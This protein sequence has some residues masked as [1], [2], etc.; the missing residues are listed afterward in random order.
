MAKKISNMKIYENQI[1]S[2]SWMDFGSFSE[3]PSGFC[4]ECVLCVYLW[5]HLLCAFASSIPFQ[6]NKT[7]CS[8]NIIFV[9]AWENLKP[10]P[11]AS[12]SVEQLPLGCHSLQLIAY[13]LFFY[14]IFKYIFFFSIFFF[15]PRDYRFN[16][17][18]V[19]ASSMLTYSQT[20]FLGWYFIDF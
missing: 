3:A 19:L 12:F 13:I 9:W 15:A 10:L 14:Y 18:Y 5:K 8:F 11:L 6:I 2:G 4:I 20:L 17:F 7:K 16:P 1:R